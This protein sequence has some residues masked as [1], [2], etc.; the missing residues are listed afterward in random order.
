MQA[1]IQLYDGTRFV[2]AVMP[3]PALPGD[4]A[5]RVR[6]RRAGDPY[7]VLFTGRNAEQQALAYARGERTRPWKV[8]R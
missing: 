4:Q 1:A 5:A 3:E 6:A 7:D 2:G 8:R